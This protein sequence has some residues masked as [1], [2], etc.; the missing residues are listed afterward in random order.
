M[1]GITLL[2]LPLLAASQEIHFGEQEFDRVVF[3][4]MSQLEARQKCE[5]ALQ[6]QLQR[7]AAVVTLTQPDHDKL[8]T[9]GRLDIHR[10]FAD[11]DRTKRQIPFGNVAKDQWQQLSS[12]S[13]AAV[14]P[15]AQQFL[16]GL[17]GNASLFEK[18]LMTTLDADSLNRVR[19]SELQ[20]ARANYADQIDT[21]LLVVGRQVSLKPEQRAAIKE[22]LLAETDPPAMFGTSLMPLYFVLANMGDIEEDLRGLFSE[23]DFRTLGKLIEAGRSS[24]R[25]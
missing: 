11:Y 7:I 24:T 14:L 20:W 2:L 9:A 18:T 21:A 8:L 3:S 25:K 23:Q 12:Q 13:H 17:H 4:Q 19:E 10:Y 22:K 6:E 16:Q 15:L 1:S 5:Q